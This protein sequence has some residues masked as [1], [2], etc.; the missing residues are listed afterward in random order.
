[1]LEKADSGSE[2]L[3]PIPLKLIEEARERIKGAVQL[4]ALLSSA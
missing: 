4:Y 3:G 1:M 2:I